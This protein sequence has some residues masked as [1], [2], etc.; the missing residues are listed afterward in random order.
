MSAIVRKNA[1][2][3]NFTQKDDWTSCSQWNKE[4]AGVVARMKI[5]LSC[6]KNYHHTEH[7]Y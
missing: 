3:N 7:R 2:S 5:H 1:N 4:M 6:R